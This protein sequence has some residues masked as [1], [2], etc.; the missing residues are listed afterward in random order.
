MKKI[1]SIDL[2]GVLN[3]YSGRYKEDEIP[4]IRDGA[5][6]FI[7]ELAKDFRIHIFT[8]RDAVLVNKWLKEN[9]LAGFIEDVGN[10]KN[11]YTSVILDDRAINFD[12]DYVKAYKAI[13][14]FKPHWR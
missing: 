3:T 11:P 5:Y 10:I 7:E 2:D 13:K 4:A 6:E 1:I 8:A 12:G 14:M 9:N